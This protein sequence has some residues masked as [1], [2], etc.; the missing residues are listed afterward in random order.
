MISH[1]ILWL[2]VLVCMLKL[3]CLQKGNQ[4]DLQLQFVWVTYSSEEFNRVDM[5]I[6]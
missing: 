3:Q 5:Y 6:P 1:R 4:R 2:Y